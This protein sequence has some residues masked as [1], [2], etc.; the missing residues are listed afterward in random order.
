MTSLAIIINKKLI[1]TLLQTTV[2][3]IPYTT[4]LKPFSEVLMHGVNYVLL[5]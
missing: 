2:S 3:F 5:Y 4:E 1:K